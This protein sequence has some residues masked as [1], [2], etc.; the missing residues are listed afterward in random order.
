MLN[1]RHVKGRSPLRVILDTRLR[2]PLSAK[3]LSQMDKFP[4][5]FFV[6]DDLPL[7]T[8]QHYLNLGAKIIQV[9]LDSMGTLSLSTVLKHLGT[10][11]IISVLVEGGKA[12]F[13]SFLKQ[14]LADRLIIA[15]APKM[16]GADGIPLI[17]KLGITQMSEIVSW[18]YHRIFRLGQDVVLDIILREY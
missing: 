14:K 5:L 2:T 13:T 18:K 3:V 11:R 4:S 10:M 8:V 1:M 16:I 12:V 9:P 7:K 15:L 17:G 6:A